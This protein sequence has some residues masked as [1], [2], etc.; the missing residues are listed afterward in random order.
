MN[1]ILAILLLFISCNEKQPNKQEHEVSKNS[2][3]VKVQLI[4]SLGTITLSVPLRYDTNF[5][6]VH[7]SD[8][9][10][11]CDMQKYRFQPKE[12]PIIKESGWIWSDKPMDSVDRFTISHTKFFPFHD[13]DTGKNLIRHD[14][15]K[16]EML[17]KTPNLPIVFDTIER[18]YDRYFSI[19][20][21][22]KSDS[23]QFKKVL[24]VTTIKG[25]EVKF[26]YQLSSKR[27]DSITRNFIKNSIELL[28]SIKISKG[29]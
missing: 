9:G 23:L 14:H 21:F 17:S 11:P 24:A 27:N 1:R 20:A 13:G 25:N 8:C 10:K 22:E 5:S 15:L 4:D 7:Y 16:E 26:E 29:P 19:I 6:W 3:A 12:F 18:I 2:K 28:R